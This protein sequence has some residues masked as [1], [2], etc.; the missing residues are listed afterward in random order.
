[1]NEDE[2]FSRL[3]IDVL[4]VED[5]LAFAELVQRMLVDDREIDFR[6][7]RVSSLSDAVTAMK[8]QLPHATL[9]DLGLPDSQ[10][11]GTVRRFVE[12]AGDS[13]LL[14][15]TAVEDQHLAQGSLALGAQEYLVKDSVSPELLS[16][17]IRYA[18]DR[19]GLINQLRTARE[20]ESRE[21][22]L[23][24]V[25]RLAAAPVLSATAAMYG[26]QTLAERAPG[27]VAD[28]Q[29]EYGRLL[30][31]ALEARVFDT[32]RPTR[33]DLR[34]MA[35]VLGYLGATP[36]DVVSIHSASLRVRMAE[37]GYERSQAY[38]EEGRIMVLELMGYLVSW[39]RN[40]A[41]GAS[42][43]SSGDKGAGQ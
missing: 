5:D 29:A 12:D 24:Q 13:A 43:P 21:R 30:D 14:V 37:V 31:E 28:M 10:G 4:L 2:R 27:R 18:V 38:L 19:Q 41:M 1:M 15:L 11:L 32:Q 35:A 39:Y 8:E 20:A 26:N 42:V 36:R 25:E 23:R 40:R 6:M 9:L 7:R 22:E 3:S 17:A 34:S 33:D 16:R